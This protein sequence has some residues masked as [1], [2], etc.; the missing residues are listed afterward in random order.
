M[1][2]CSA[3]ALILFL[4][5]RLSP[6]KKIFILLHIPILRIYT[7]LYLTH[8]FSFHFGSLLKTGMSINEALKTLAEQ[9][10]MTF[11][12]HEAIKMQS[13]LKRGERLE[14]AIQ[15]RPFYVKEFS[16][17]IYNGQLNGMLG[18]ALFDYSGLILR[19]MEE[20]TKTWLAVIQPMTLV[21]IGLL[22]SLLFLSIMLPV[23]NVMNG[24]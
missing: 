20:Q 10:L 16:H 17:V 7:R 15:S 23:F 2:A 3:V 13:D 21:F 4:Y 14:Q 9:Q 1:S 22:V 6:D 11:F 12:Q 24:L 8:Y 5:H 19:K 18:A